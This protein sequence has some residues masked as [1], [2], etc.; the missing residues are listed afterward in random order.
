M[1]IGYHGAK[2]AVPWRFDGSPAMGLTFLENSGRCG[3]RSAISF[4]NSDVPP[5]SPA[6]SPAP[7]RRP[8]SA[9]GP[10][11]VCDESKG[12]KLAFTSISNQS[13]APAPFHSTPPPNPGEP[14]W[15]D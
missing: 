1:L 7:I 13:S 14:Q 12:K 4:C 5:F 2:S 9:P 6:P 15:N 11:S 8:A 3:L 10:V